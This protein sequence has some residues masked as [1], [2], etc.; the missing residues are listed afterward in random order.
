MYKKQNL[1][2]Y[3]VNQAK[4]LESKNL[5]FFV[6]QEIIRSVSK[7]KVYNLHYVKSPIKNI[8]RKRTTKFTKIADR[9]FS[10]KKVSLTELKD[11]FEKTK[12]MVQKKRKKRNITERA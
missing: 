8:N 1:S 11:H 2:D 3:T 7:K 6:K 9:Y 10:N 12:E 5:P 4:M